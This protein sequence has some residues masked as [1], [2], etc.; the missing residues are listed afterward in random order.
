MLNALRGAMEY[1]HP[2]CIAMGQ[3]MP[4]DEVLRERIIVM[5]EA[6]GHEFKDRKPKTREN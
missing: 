4:G 5:G 1:H 2:G 6:V 3:G